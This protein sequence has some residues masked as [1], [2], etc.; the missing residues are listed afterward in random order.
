MRWRGR[1][2][3]SRLSLALLAS[4]LLPAACAETAGD[5]GVSVDTLESGAV[6]VQ[7]SRPIGWTDP[8]EGWRVALRARVAASP[9]EDGPFL[10]SNVRDVEI[11]AHGRLYV[12]DNQ[13]H[14][15]G[16][17]DTTGAY[18]RTIGREG[19]GP[20]E[21][22]GPDGV[23]WGPGGRLWVSDPRNARYTVFDTAGTLVRTLPRRLSSWG[24]EWDGVFGP[25]GRLLETDIRREEDFDENTLLAVRFDVS[26]E[27]AIPTDTFELVRPPEATPGFRV[28]GDGRSGYI[29]VP[30]APRH[31][32]HFDGGGGVWSGSGADFRLVRT[33]L[34]GDTARIAVWTGE[35]PPVTDGDLEEWR[36]AIEEDWG[37][38][39]LRQIDL[40]RVP[41]VKTAYTHFFLDDRRHL[42][43][44]RGQGAG[45]YG[46]RADSTVFDVLDPQGRWLGPVVVREELSL[47][48]PIA[49]RGP[50]MATATTDELDLPT[51][52][53]FRLER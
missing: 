16:V 3:T 52:L 13:S 37:A 28:S 8:G 2:K 1:A 7:S 27:A 48:V 22:S 45:A 12:L 38:G 19:E 51:V 50:W 43:A 44:A 46:Q 32:L 36:S 33:A 49:F 14:T 17:F 18:V 26:G 10:L 23:T 25:E 53:L 34:S 9:D 40:S 20:G 31:R 15:I 41:E 5:S 6:R 21:L 42:W 29:Q 24:W 11:D 30:F 47:F 4:A 39:A 35:R